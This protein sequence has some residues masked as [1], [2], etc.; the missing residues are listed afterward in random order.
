MLENGTLV[1]ERY[2]IIEKIGIGGMANVYKA[3]D[4]KLSRTVAVKVLKEEFSEDMTFVNKFRTEAQS[5]AGLEHPNI[6]NVYDVGSE[7]GF[8]YEIDIYPEWTDK[9]IMEIELHS[10]NQQI[11]FPEGINVIREVTDDPAYSN[12]EIARIR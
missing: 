11:V 10:E 5:A 2:E 6:V 12:H 1:A 7:N 9:A 8:Y 4:I 3:Q